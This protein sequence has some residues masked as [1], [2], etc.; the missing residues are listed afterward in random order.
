MKDRNELYNLASELYHSKQYQKAAELLKDQTDSQS[1]VLCGLSLQACRK[2]PE[3]IACYDKAISQNPELVIA[4]KCRGNARVELNDNDNAIRDF[5]QILKL[6]P[7]NIDAAVKLISLLKKAS[8]F[9]EAI[10]VC[11]DA[12]ELTP[13]NYSLLLHLGII[14]SLSYH[15][16]ETAETYM[17]VFRLFPE[18]F[19]TQPSILLYLNYPGTISNN[20]IF[21]FHREW[22]QVASRS[23]VAALDTMPLP[24]KAGEKEKIKLGYY[25]PD[26]ITHPVSFFFTSLI[27]AH[28]RNKF[29]IHCF[30]DSSVNDEMTKTIKAESTVWHDVS[31]MQVNDLI[32]YIRDTRL[33]IIVDL[34]G[35]TS[36]RMQIFSKRVAPIQM[37]YLGYPNTTGIA[38]MDYRLTDELTEPPGAEQLHSE[39]M[40]YIP[41]GAWAYSPNMAMPQPGPP[42]VERNGFFSFGSFNNTNKISDHTIEIYCKVLSNCPNSKLLLKNKRLVHEYIRDRL[43]EKFKSHGIGP[44]RIVFIKPTKDISSHLACY[45]FV[46]LA[47]DTFPYNG[48]TT[49]FDALWMGVPVLTIDGNC[50]AAKVSASIMTRLNLKPFIADNEKSFVLRA[51]MNTEKPETLKM[52]RPVL[53]S[54]LEKSSLMDGQR[55]ANEMELLYMDCYNRKLSENRE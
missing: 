12:L 43:L 13:D 21:N 5:V 16:R 54:M 50:H 3:A 22:D 29:E 37:T 45:N 39:K 9:A 55:L 30:H 35:P 6:C 51:R 47:L 4:W 41:G 18:K 7:E 24:R 49:T 14:Y 15:V 33:D 28:D 31:N 19:I 32:Q 26:F 52:L 27:H 40:L 25:S 11:K 8:C 20:D 17:K 23:G 10:Q 42:P 53:R 34:A 44:E 36:N 2:L 48:T 46:D 38:N 1:C